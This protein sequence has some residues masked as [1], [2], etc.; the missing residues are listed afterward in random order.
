[1]SRELR[2]FEAYID[3][4]VIGKQ[5]IDKLKVP[6]LTIYP[7]GDFDVPLGV[8]DL[9]VYHTRRSNV[10]GHDNLERIC[11]GEAVITVYNCNNLK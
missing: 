1:M 4:N 7:N 8:T 5:A 9:S 3:Y 2:D 6:R 11:A 10:Y